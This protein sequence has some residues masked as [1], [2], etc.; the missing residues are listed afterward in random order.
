MA[1][2]ESGGSC[3]FHRRPEIPDEVDHA[4]GERLRH[5]P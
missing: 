3:Y 1:F 4:C 5:A 2:D